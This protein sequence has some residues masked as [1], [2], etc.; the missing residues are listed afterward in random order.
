MEGIALRAT[1]NRAMR[2]QIFAFAISV[3]AIGGGIY[4]GLDG[5][6]LGGG[7][8]GAGGIVLLVG[9]FLRERKTQTK[10]LA[11]KNPT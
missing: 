11:R 7:I 8:L 9:L 5:K 2:G 4:L 1:L 6:E 10:D 3:L